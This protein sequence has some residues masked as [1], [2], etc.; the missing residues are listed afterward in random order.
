MASI[1]RILKSTFSAI[2]SPFLTFGRWLRRKVTSLRNVQRQHDAQ[3]DNNNNN[4]TTRLQHR[5]IARDDTPPVSASGVMAENNSHTEN[6]WDMCDDAYSETEVTRLLA[7]MESSDDRLIFS[8][9]L[10]HLAQKLPQGET[11]EVVYSACQDV[12]NLC[13][14]QDRLQ[15]YTLSILLSHEISDRHK[16]LLIQALQEQSTAQNPPPEPPDNTRESE[17][18]REYHASMQLLSDAID[19]RR[20]VCAEKHYPYTQTV[21]S[22]DELITHFKQINSPADDSCSYDV[23]LTDTFTFL[24]QLDLALGRLSLP[25]ERLAWITSK[26]NH[27]KSQLLE[28]S[29]TRLPYIYRHGISQG[30]IESD[31]LGLADA[32]TED[33]QGVLK[34]TNGSSAFGHQFVKDCGRDHYT[35]K[36]ERLGTISHY[37]P[38]PEALTEEA[39]TLFCDN[40]D[41]VAGTLSKVVNQTYYSYMLKLEAARLLQF[42]PWN[43]LVLSGNPNTTQKYTITRK[44][45]GD[46]TV[47]TEMMSD[48]PVCTLGK[49]TMKLQ[50]ATYNL[51]CEATLD[52]KQLKQ[53]VLSASKPDVRIEYPATDAIQWQDH[54]GT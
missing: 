46:V 43:I 53:G 27:L 20:Q 8:E 35:L 30:C 48:N 12:A 51:S 9:H 19:A 49:A 47:K 31:A 4:V 54:D 14:S 26:V 28:R 37:S 22:I 44:E 33:W 52:G 25:K 5:H 29:L 23:A 15:H 16:P 45:N 32:S 40:N 21:C 1:S 13:L 36:D 11:R 17:W 10:M 42:S 38:G 34:D 7:K 2:G 6:D 24:D 41:H 39:L 3:A 18:S 50:G